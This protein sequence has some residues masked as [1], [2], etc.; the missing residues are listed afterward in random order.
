MTNLIV[1]GLL[2]G[3]EIVIWGEQLYKPGQSEIKRRWPTGNVMLFIVSHLFL[4][5]PHA[6]NWISL[7]GGCKVPIKTFCF[8]PCFW[9]WRNYA[10]WP[11]NATQPWPMT[12]EL[13]CKILRQFQNIIYNYL[14]HIAKSL[15][16]LII[17]SWLCSNLIFIFLKKMCMVKKKTMY[18]RYLY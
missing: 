1:P 4:G 2:S 14:S 9:G 10:A 15:S 7:L 12:H 6:E 17:L 3:G 11:T 5:A 16:Q 8:G 13:N 18:C